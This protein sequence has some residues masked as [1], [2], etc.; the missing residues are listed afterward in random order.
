M[1]AQRYPLSCRIFM[2]ANRPPGQPLPAALREFVRYAL[3]RD[4]QHA[5]ADD[6]IFL[7]LPAAVVQ[8]ELNRVTA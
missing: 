6:G 7:P 2:F 1:A 8:R 4:G 3:S 5:V